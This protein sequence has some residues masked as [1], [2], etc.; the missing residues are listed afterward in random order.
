MRNPIQKRLANLESWQQC[1]LWPACVSGCTP[2]SQ[3]F[4]I[5]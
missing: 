4:A 3:C 5:L 1:V 2:I